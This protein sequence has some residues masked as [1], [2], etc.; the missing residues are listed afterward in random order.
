MLNEQM[1]LQYINSN[2]YLLITGYD[3]REDMISFLK[4]YSKECTED[5]K[6]INSIV[7]T[8]TFDEVNLIMSLLYN[9]DLN[10]VTTNYAS[11]KYVVD[12]IFRVYKAD[13]RNKLLE[14]LL[15]LF[16]QLRVIPT[17][18]DV[19]F[20]NAFV[21]VLKALDSVFDKVLAQLNCGEKVNLLFVGKIN[22]YD[23][24]SFDVLYKLGATLVLID[25]YTKAETFYKPLYELLSGNIKQL[26]GI[27]DIC[28]RLPDSIIENTSWVQLN[29]K[30]TLEDC[31]MTV[32]KDNIKRIDEKIK[33]VNLGFSGVLDKEIY[34]Q[35]VNKFYLEHSYD[36]LLIDNTFK[37][38]T[39]DEISEYR[40]NY[41]DKDL[42]YILKEFN[43]FKYTTIPKCVNYALNKVLSKK[44]YNSE[45]H[46]NNEQMVLSIWVLRICKNFFAK[47]LNIVKVPI[48]VLWNKN[49]EKMSELV[50]VL[51]ELP[52]D[53]IHFCPNKLNELSTSQI[54]YYDLGLSNMD[55]LDFPKTLKDV[56]KV[57][58]VAYKAQEEIRTALSQEVGIFRMKQF[59]DLNSVML[60][61]TYEEMNIL[62]SQQ[63]KFRP[64]FSISGDVV[65]VPSI[66]AKIEG[67]EDDVVNYLSLIKD[68]KSKN[69][70][71]I[72]KFPFIQSV[73]TNDYRYGFIKQIVY[74]GAVDLKRYMQSE[75]YSYSL[76]SDETQQFIMNRIQNFLSLE[77]CSKLKSKDIFIVLYVLLNMSQELLQLIHTFD[78]TGDIPKVV[79]FNSDSMSLSFE[80]CTLIMFLKSIGFDI[81][82]Y[83]PTGYKIIEQYIDSKWFNSMVIGKYDFS[84][85]VSDIENASVAKPKKSFFSSLFG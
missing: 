57:E 59:K 83:V 23:M 4:N 76:Y 52:I 6:F 7:S 69:A 34:L 56:T 29:Q 10:L 85:S 82:V 33:V 36:I 14:I 41:A 18:T 8:P 63:A 40:I 37:M 68:K 81:A 28:S 64:S 26:Q 16:K 20:K 31:L 58:T 48:I 19:C 5:T 71:F 24:L 65:L 66:F 25:F 47:E 54:A 27:E 42:E 72:S 61:T 60:K 12:T 75:F 50:Q 17:V 38:P 80:E 21:R 49:I 73:N 22:K 78:F 77:W 84:L 9:N 30:N 70:L 1:G 79:I 51:S 3:I 44:V 74:N 2:K 39:Y 13:F 32:Y 55:I 67:V 15:S 62:W 35:L 11:L 45:T 53:I 43:C 46:K